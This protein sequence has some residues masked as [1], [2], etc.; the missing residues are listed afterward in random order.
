MEVQAASRLVA[1]RL[2]HH[3]E[4]HA[5]LLGQ[6]VRRELE[7]HQVVGAGERLVEAEIHLVLA[8]RVLV[9]ELQHVQAAGLKPRLQ[10]MQEVALPR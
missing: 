5:A 1:E 10:R 7:K 6:R 4:Q 3:R 9:V 8:V 2:G